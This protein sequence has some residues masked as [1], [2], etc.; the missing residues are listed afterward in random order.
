M[1]LPGG[2]LFGGKTTLKEGHR[3][4]KFFYRENPGCALGWQICLS[5]QSLHIGTPVDFLPLGSVAHTD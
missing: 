4:G 1:H 2:L 3:Q 5:Q